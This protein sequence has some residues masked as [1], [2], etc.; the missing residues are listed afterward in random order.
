MYPAVPQS[1]AGDLSA[2]SFRSAAGPGLQDPRQLAEFVAGMRPANSGLDVT[3]VMACDAGQ[4][5][6]WIEGPEAAVAI[7]WDRI[8]LDPRHRVHWAGAPAVV[9]AR[10]FPGSP[11]K[12]AVTTASLARIDTCLVQDVVAHDNPLAAYSPPLRGAICAVDETARP[13]SDAVAEALRQL[14]PAWR[15]AAGKLATARALALADVLTATD[16]LVARRHLDILLKQ[17]DLPETAA[18]VQAVLD[19]LQTGWMT[20][21][22]T[23]LQ[24][25]LVVTMLQSALR[26]RLDVAERAQTVGC[27]LVSALPGTPDMCGVMLKVALLRQ[28]GWS[29]RLLL[30]QA[31]TEI[32]SLTHGLQPD[33]IVLAGSR[34]S[35]GP[36][37]L[38]ML[39]DLL[40]K[41]SSI[42]AAPVIL[43]GK[44]AETVPQVV[45]NQG[46]A[47]VC[48]ALPW[49]TLI[50]S[51]LVPE[52]EAAEP[53]QI[54]G[55][56]RGGRGLM[57]D[58]VLAAHLAAHR[59]R[60]ASGPA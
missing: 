33:L 55:P 59:A 60:A 48:A 40:P 31:V 51:Q 58:H 25:Q 27:A 24:R 14:D 18:L 28:A 56:R 45:L 17:I 44:L 20:G 38:A 36:A 2:L 22:I 32:Q 39:A 47:A 42:C 7:L 3:G 50:A 1:R 12:L 54:G 21:R 5:Q 30:P 13:P 52:P 35:A 6:Q 4:I 15:G 19:H 43:G 8:Q 46:A 9:T 57:A 34:M 41:L 26:V 23:A 53:M 16:P 37:E 49:I 29:V 10:H 11:M